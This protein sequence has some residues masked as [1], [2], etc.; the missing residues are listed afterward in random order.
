MP[1]STAKNA[2]PKLALVRAELMK[3]I[4][5]DLPDM[6]GEPPLSVT[7]IVEFALSALNNTSSPVRRTGEKIMIRMYEIDPKCVRK[8]M[9]PDTERNR[10]S[11]H[12]YK[13]LFEAFERR[14]QRSLSSTPRR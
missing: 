13:Y 8:I 7:K 10:R 6:V 4:I 9:P 1:L 2:N 3:Y 5:D 11:N 12:N 14:D